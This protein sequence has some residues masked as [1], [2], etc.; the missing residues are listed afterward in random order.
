MLPAA[1]PKGSTLPALC[2]IPP[3][4]PEAPRVLEPVV[5]HRISIL[6]AIAHTICILPT[7][8]QISVV[9]SCDLGSD[10]MFGGVIGC[11]WELIANTHVQFG[12]VVLVCSGGLP[13]APEVFRLRVGGDK[14]ML[15]SAA[16]MCR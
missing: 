4:L 8:S 9:A 13:M 16:R 6:L 11:C 15:A 2:W 5:P 3:I 14:H 10:L 12:K 7:V 1:C